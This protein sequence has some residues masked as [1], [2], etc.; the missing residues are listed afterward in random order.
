MTN[1][2]EGHYPC[3]VIS[4]ISSSFNSLQGVGLG[5]FSQYGVLLNCFL[6]VFNCKNGSEKLE[7]LLLFAYC[8]WA[9]LTKMEASAG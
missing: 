9:H 1:M 3:V 6:I 7:E 2:W 5:H 4:R 8:V